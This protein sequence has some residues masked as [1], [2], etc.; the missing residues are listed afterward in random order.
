MENINLNDWDEARYLELNAYFRVRIQVLVDSDPYIREMMEQEKS[1]QLKD[2]IDRLSDE[3]QQLWHEFLRL[4]SIKLH[5]DMKNHLE[6]KGT[7]YNPR[8]GFS[9]S[10]SDDD[11]EDMPP[12]W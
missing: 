1:M 3:D 11:D 5:R 4:D 8:D 6:G 9:G 10:V 12:T 2:L 7:P